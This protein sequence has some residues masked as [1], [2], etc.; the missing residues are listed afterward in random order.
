MVLLGSQAQ[1]HINGAHLLLRTY[2]SD[3]F[4]CYLVHNLHGGM[5]VDLC[6]ERFKTAKEA[7]QKAE[8]VAARAT[9]C[10]NF[11]VHWEPT[12]SIISRAELS[13]VVN[14]P[15]GPRHKPAS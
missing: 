3:G 6:Q 1:L 4:Y 2:F 11:V 14:L 13:R 12:K 9:G 10:A 5:P 8:E 7:M 15:L